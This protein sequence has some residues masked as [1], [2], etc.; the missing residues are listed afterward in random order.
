MYQVAVIDDMREVR[1]FIQLAFKE[2]EFQ[3]QLF[4]AEDGQKGIELATKLEKVDL[5]IVDYNMPILNGL[6]A[7]QVILKI[8]RYQNTPVMLYTTESN[9]ELI[10]EAKRLSRQIKW[11]I[12]P[13]AAEPF[14]VGVRALLKIPTPG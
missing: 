14:L 10:Q 4:E 6:Q 11:V 7:L 1:D 9:D 2:A 13:L 8:D 12:K 3:S 5:F